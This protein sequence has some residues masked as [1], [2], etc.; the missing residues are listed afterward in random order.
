[1]IFKISWLLWLP[2]DVIIK[3]EKWKNRYCCPFGVK[4]KNLDFHLT[5]LFSF[6]QFRFPFMNSNF[7]IQEA[8]PHT[9]DMIYKLHRQGLSSIFIIHLPPFNTKAFDAK[10]LKIFMILVIIR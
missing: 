4:F 9:F 7:C 3:F 8:H 2:S 6:K 1:M 10:K 5:Y